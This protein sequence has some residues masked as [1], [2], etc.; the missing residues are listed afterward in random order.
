MSKL[1]LFCIGDYKAARNPKHDAN[2]RPIQKGKL[3]PEEAKKRCSAGGKKSG[4]VRRKHGNA[5]KT[6]QYILGLDAV[7]NA[8]ENLQCVAIPEEACTNMTAADEVRRI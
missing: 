1:F 6:I 2:L 8:T 5:K 4:E 3:S 7:G